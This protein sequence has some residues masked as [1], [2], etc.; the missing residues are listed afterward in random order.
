MIVLVNTCGWKEREERG[1]L[2]GRTGRKQAGSHKRPTA[3]SVFL[4]LQVFLD[5]AAPIFTFP[6]LSPNVL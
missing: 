2:E 3:H 5:T 4:T 1:K 6:W